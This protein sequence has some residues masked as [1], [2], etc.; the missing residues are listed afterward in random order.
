W[1]QTGR[2]VL[3]RC[4]QL[5]AP[6]VE[7]AEA[8]TVLPEPEV[9]APGAPAGYTLRVQQDWWARLIRGHKEAAAGFALGGS[10]GAIAATV[11]A[12]SLLAPLTLLGAVAA[13]IWGL[14]RGV[15]RAAEKELQGARTELK[16]HLAEMLHRLRAHFFD[17]NSTDGERSRIENYFGG[18]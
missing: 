3:D 12:G 8:L 2:Q 14:F 17:P 16:K 5:L 10:A 1:R 11:L 13:G 9:G 7:A 4:R 18:L 15:A 6:F